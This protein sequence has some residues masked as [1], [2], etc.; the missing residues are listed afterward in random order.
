MNYFLEDLKTIYKE[1]K[2][3]EEGLSEA[4]ASK[5]L[6]INGTNT[7]TEKKGKS[8]LKIFF[9]QFNDMM[10]IILL[11]VAVIMGIYGFLYSN[12][13]TDTIVI[14]VVVLINAIMG[15]V[16]EAKA[17]VTLEGLKKYS[18]TKVK[19][20]RKGQIKV[21]DS[22]YLVPGDIILLEA[23]DKVPVDARIISESNVLVDEAALT[24]ESTP[25]SKKNKTIKINSA[26]IQEQINMLF[27]G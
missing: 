18:V 6:S 12:D 19:V 20:K 17:E 10:I 7:L 24:G 5:R 27:S 11:I 1:L 3:S 26:Q 16:Q 8:K 4:E 25:V 13:Y 15:F 21:I 14:L 2:V 22:K 9:Y 23:G